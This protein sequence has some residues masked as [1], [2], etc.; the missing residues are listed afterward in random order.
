MFL[1]WPQLWVIT[2]ELS[3][4]GLYACHEKSCPQ[5]HLGNEIQRTVSYD[6]T[7][8]ERWGHFGTTDTLWS[9]NLNIMYLLFFSDMFPIQEKK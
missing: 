9:N 1:F 6:H 4:H 3:E 2:N 8:Y 5:V 7:T